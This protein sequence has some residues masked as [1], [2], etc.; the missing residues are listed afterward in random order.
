MPSLIGEKIA[1]KYRAE[2][3]L[4]Q[5]GLGI[6]LRAVHLDLK[7]PVAIKVLTA[8]DEESVE[9]FM[10]EAR[11]AVRLKGE[12][13]T[14]VL[15]VGNLKAGTPFM[16]MELLEGE[17]LGDLVSRGPLAVP[18][19]VALVLQVCEGL[20]EAHAM[21]VIH[22]DL[23]PRN[24]FLTHRAN[25]S[26]LM[27]VLDFGLAKSVEDESSDVKLTTTTAVL[28]S[29]AYMSP[30][31]VHATRDVDL[32]TDI[33]SLGVVLYELLTQRVPFEAPTAFEIMSKIVHA[34]PTPIRNHVPSIPVGVAAIVDKCLAKGPRERF[35]NVHDLVVALEPY[36]PPSV[37]GA[38]DRVR[39]ALFAPQP[40]IVPTGVYTRGAMPSVRTNDTT[41][42]DASLDSGRERNAKTARTSFLAGALAVI[43]AAMGWFAWSTSR[44]VGRARQAS[45]E[46]AISE[47]VVRPDPASAPSETPVP[48]AS[49]LPAAS[50]SAASVSETPVKAVSKPAIVVPKRPSVSGSKAP[51]P[52]QHPES[53]S[54]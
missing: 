51:H 45:T 11:A 31:Q 18:D 1:D 46:Q 20:A 53:A 29:P 30:E 14:R 50:A 3:I 5:G 44:V 41:H 10:R 6:V 37:R 23:K 4:G 47:R 17:D 34:P 39:A 32:R 35:A 38:A 21:G 36:A 9:R 33:W 2:S 28:G 25:G 22:R 43:V 8:E 12:H 15:D 7:M 19:A 54:F 48:T 42:T 52:L 24:L 26:V 40:V 13:T 49:A 16:V 27:K